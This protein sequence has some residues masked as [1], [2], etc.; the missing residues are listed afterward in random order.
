MYKWGSRSF[1]VASPVTQHTLLKIK[2]NFSTINI[3]VLC[4]HAIET[5]YNERDGWI[6]NSLP[7]EIIINYKSRK[8]SLKIINKNY[9]ASSTKLVVSALNVWNATYLTNP[10]MYSTHV[11][12]SLKCRYYVPRNFLVFKTMCSQQLLN[13]YK[14]HFLILL[15]FLNLSTWSAIFDMS[16]YTDYILH[17]CTFKKTFTFISSMLW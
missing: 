7:H 15:L 6:I 1:V 2:F 10:Y 14:W 16:N 17:G 13:Q 9:I 12:L 3:H 4:R 11:Y 5:A 8:I